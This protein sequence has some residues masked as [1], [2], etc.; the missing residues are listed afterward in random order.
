MRLI[1]FDVNSYTYPNGTVGLEDFRERFEGGEFLIGSTG[2]GKST[3]LRMMN[4]LIPE[5]YSG[6]LDGR[7]TVFGKKPNP[8]DVFLIRQDPR[9]MVTCLDIVDEVAFAAI[10]RGT[11]VAEAKR[12]AEQI[13]EEIG[14][15][16]LIGRKT[17]E[18][19]TGELQLVEIASA[20]VANAR[21]LVLDEP[22]AHLSYKNARRVISL[23]KDFPHIVSEHRLEFSR[24]FD[25]T[26][27]LGLRE[28]DIE[29][30]EGEIG[31]VV[32]SGIVEIR[33]GEI[34]AITGD[35]GVGKSMM[36]RRIMADMRHVGAVL[37]HPSYHLTERTVE[38]EV[39]A[40]LLREFGLSSIAKRHPQ[41]LSS[42]QMRRVAIAKAFKSEI[43]LLDE[44][45][46]GQDINFRRK[47][48]QLLRKYKKT[49]II[50]TH[51]EDFAK[52]CDRVI[53]LDHRFTEGGS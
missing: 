26:V 28:E 51:D 3:V 52:M 41:S 15:G 21:I 16:C 49:A 14:L 8:V 38:K 17:F 32:Y 44:P 10:Q 18:V 53:E 48:I 6:K 1:E 46:A 42:G 36:L 23:L 50:A 5:F 37:Q 9:E 13:L 35:N 30:P 4:G 29:I 20:I 47:L 39:G 19:S 24:F 40:E 34:L 33:E 11:N 2:S 27:D 25:R 31:D 22:F 12:D 43:L 45:T 7:V